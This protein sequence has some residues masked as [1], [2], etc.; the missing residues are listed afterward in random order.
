M[1]NK[2][3][4]GG[5]LY[6]LTILINAF[7]LSYIWI[8]HF[9]MTGFLSSKAVAFLFVV[10]LILFSYAYSKLYHKIRSYVPD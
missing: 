6:A 10:S 2:T 7:W 1:K 5:W 3:K 8:I 4:V 9:R